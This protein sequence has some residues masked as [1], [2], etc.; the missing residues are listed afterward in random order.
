MNRILLPYIWKKRYG[1]TLRSAWNQKLGNIDVRG[2]NNTANQSLLRMPLRGT[3]E[4]YPFMPRG[5]HEVFCCNHNLTWCCNFLR[6][7]LSSDGGPR[8]SESFRGQGISS[9]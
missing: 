7:L 1:S 2:H 8:K 5:L 4:F 3:A 9:R 6:L